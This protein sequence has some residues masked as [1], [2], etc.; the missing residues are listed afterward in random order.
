MLTIASTDGRQTAT[1]L[2]IPS[3]PD[4]QVAMPELVFERF[5]G[6]HFLARVVRGDGDEREIVLTPAIME[7]ELVT[8]A[9]NAGQ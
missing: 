8:T 4:E 9:S 3:S 7:R 1:I 5:A 6:Q 2:T